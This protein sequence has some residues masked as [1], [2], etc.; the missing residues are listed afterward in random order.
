MLEERSSLGTIEE[1]KNQGRN[2]EIGQL[3]WTLLSN[4]CGWIP[5]RGGNQVC[6]QRSNP[7]QQL[8]LS[9]RQK[10]PFQQYREPKARLSLVGPWVG[11][12]A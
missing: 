2:Q 11:C 5:Q 4:I 9:S 7:P 12:H 3:Q 6:T 1:G 10:C 8:Q